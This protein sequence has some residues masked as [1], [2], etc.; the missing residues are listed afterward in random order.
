MALITPYYRFNLLRD[1]D[2]N[3][4]VDCAVAAGADLLVTHDRGFDVLRQVAFSVVPAG[5]IT[6]LAALLGR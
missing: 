3:K 6:V 2:D 5:D 1:P 4:F